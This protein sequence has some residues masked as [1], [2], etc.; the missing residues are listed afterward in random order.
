MFEGNF[1]FKILV[2][3]SGQAILHYIAVPVV[4]LDTGKAFKF[5]NSI[6]WYG[7]FVIFGLYAFF[8][9]TRWGQGSKDKGKT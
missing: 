3:T 9:I 2:W 1:L 8:S 4:L 5:L 6:Y 7:T